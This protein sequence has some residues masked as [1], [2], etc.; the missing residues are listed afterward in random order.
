MAII[1]EATWDF[2]LLNEIGFRIT[3]CAV[4]LTANSNWEK[5]IYEMY[6]FAFN[7]LNGLCN[8]MNLYFQMKWV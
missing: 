5:L 1:A 4:F 7:G 3:L 8:M 6:L 2:F